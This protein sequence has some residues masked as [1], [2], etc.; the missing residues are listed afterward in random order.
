[1]NRS[2]I[3]GI[4]RPQ[5]CAVAMPSPAQG[6][7]FY[8]V[9]VEPV[10]AHLIPTLS[11]LLMKNQHYFIFAIVG[12]VKSRIMSHIFAG[13]YA[14]LILIPDPITARRSHIKLFH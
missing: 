1:M 8:G 9:A 12:L 2:A 10:T 6:Y 13:N 4:G 7:S 14:G 11:D 5:A 3:Q